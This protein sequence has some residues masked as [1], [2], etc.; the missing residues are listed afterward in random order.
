[1]ADRITDLIRRT[2]LFGIGAVAITADRA[3]EIVNDLVERGEITTEQGKSMVKELM[4]RGT[5]ARKQLRDMVKV[6]VKKAL[7]EADISSK[8]DIKRLEDKIDRL[9]LQEKQPHPGIHIEGTETGEISP[10]AL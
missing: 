1:M 8:Q 7:E 3:Q 6:E 5:E 2:L 10:E 9:I 4:K